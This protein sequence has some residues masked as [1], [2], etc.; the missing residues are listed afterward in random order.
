[1]EGFT[2][3]TYLGMLACLLCLG[4]AAALLLVSGGFLF[5]RRH[6][7]SLNIF[8]LALLLGS[9]PAAILTL[10]DGIRDLEHPL[11]ALSLLFAGVAQ[12]LVARRAR[13]YYGV[14]LACAAG[15]A[16]FTVVAFRADV[17]IYPPTGLRAFVTAA[18]IL[19]AVGSVIPA[20][21]G[22]NPGQGRE[23]PR[24]SGAH[25]DVAGRDGG[26]VSLG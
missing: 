15:V 26:G 5:A 10:Q 1:M 24:E 18:S 21:L 20:A 13:R 14:S 25:R 23:G 2:V 6:Q 12:L 8:A 11:L 9:I 7:D 17:G 16:L 22:R 19:L 4:V 3:W